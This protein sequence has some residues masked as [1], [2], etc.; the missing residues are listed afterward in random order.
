MTDDCELADC[1]DAFGIGCTVVLIMFLIIASIARLTRR[2][3][4]G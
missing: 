2:L 3:H 4:R 1:N